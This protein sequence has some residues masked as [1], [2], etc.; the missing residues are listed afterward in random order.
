[1][2]SLKDLQTIGGFVPEE[3]VQKHIK[4]SANG[5]DYTAD[6]WV[7]R[8][9]IVEWEKSFLGVDLSGNRTGHG[10]AAVIRLG[11]G[12]EQMTV[13]QASS[14]H[15]SLATAMMGAIMEVNSPKKT[16]PPE[17]NSSAS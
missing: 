4:W 2:T 8:L 7:R 13:A 1:M 15:P 16:S 6:I 10:L 14:L 9:G 5:E 12:S 3:P 11:D 17:K